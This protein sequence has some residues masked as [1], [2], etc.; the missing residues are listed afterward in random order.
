MMALSQDFV[1]ALGNEASWQTQDLE[2]RLRANPGF[3][4]SPLHPTL[5]YMEVM[6]SVGSTKQP[7]LLPAAQE[8]DLHV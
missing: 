8:R 4:S 5:S 7:P 1:G 2:V 3:C 6:L